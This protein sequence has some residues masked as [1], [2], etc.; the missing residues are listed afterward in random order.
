MTTLNKIGENVYSGF[1]LYQKISSVIGA[2]FITIIG[3]FFI[4]I[5][6]QIIIHR[7]H[8]LKVNGEVCGDSVCSTVTNID[9]KGNKSITTACNTD[10]TYTAKDNTI[11][12]CKESIGHGSKKYKDKQKVSVFYD[13]TISGKPD[14][15]PT[16]KKTGWIMILISLLLMIII[17]LYVYFIFKYKAFA[18]IQGVMNVF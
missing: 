2:I 4:Y 12:T 5:G 13:P 7:S 9:N 6:R 11:N 16:S 15:N 10:V 8:L 3:L 14:L 17:W 18:A 1:A